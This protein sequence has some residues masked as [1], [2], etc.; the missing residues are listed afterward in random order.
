[1]AG[2]QSFVGPSDGADGFPKVNQDALFEDLPKEM[3]RLF[4]EVESYVNRISKEWGKTVKETTD[5]VKGVEG[6]K[7]GAGRL[8]LA[9]MSRNE[10]IGMGLGLAAMGAQT[11][12]SMAPNTMAAVTQRLSADSYAGM[13]GMSSRQAILQANRQVGG[14]ATSAMGPT[15]AA[16]NLAYGGYTANSLSSKNIMGQLAGLSAQSGMSNEAAAASVGGMNGMMFLRAGIRIRDNNGNLKPIDQ[17][18]NQVYNFLYRGRQISSEEAQLV[19]N[20]GS[21]SYSTI[22]QLA[23]GDQNLMQQ[24]QAGIVARTRA[25]SGKAY[26]AAMN[27][28]DPNKMLDIM[29]VDKSSPTR[30]QFRFNSS[31]NRKLAATEQGLV[32][33][34]NVA[35]RTTASVNDGFSTMAGLLGPINQGLM[36][37]KGI[38]QTMPGAG[39]TGAALSGLGGAASSL[40]GAAL[41]AK[42]LGN[43]LGGKGGGIGGFGGGGGG[44]A[45]LLGKFGPAT[46]VLGKGSML[47]KAGRVGL[48]AGVYAG[49]EWLQKFL[50]KK[51]KNL[52]SWARKLGN[53]AFDLG[54]GALTGLAAGGLGGAVAGTVAGGAGDLL[55]G[56]VGGPNDY[57]NLG[58][59]GVAAST[60]TG[61]TPKVYPTPAGTRIT[62]PFGP[63]RAD[64]HGRAGFHHGLDL[65]V[66]SG[67]DVRAFKDGHVSYIGN[68][69]KGYGNYIE[70]K[71]DDGTA[72]RYGHLRQVLV[73]RGQKVK[74]GQVIAKSGGNASDPGHGDSLHQHLHFEVLKNGQKVDPLPY[75]TGSSDKSR[76]YSKNNNSKSSGVHRFLSSPHNPSQKIVP[77]TPGSLSSAPLTSLLSQVSASGEP[78]SWQ[79]V[80]RKLPKKDAQK[81]IDSLPDS[82]KG[83]VTSDKKSLIRTISQQGFHGKALRT[84]YA[85]SIAESGGRS[86]AVGDVGLQDSKWGPSIGLFQIRSLK[87]WQQYNDPYRDASRL[88]NPNYN[89]QAAW[90]KSSN[91]RSFKAWSTYTSGSFLKHLSEADAMAKQTGVGGPAASVNLPSNFSTAGGMNNQSITI[92]GGRS[93]GSHVNVNLHMNVTIAHGSIQETDRIVRLIGEKLKNDHTLKQIASTL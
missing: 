72:T 4:K 79:D 37:L 73:T 22:A 46:G 16:M 77:I 1:M 64:D 30:S 18:I 25:K 87:H 48:A 33:G 89:A 29:G 11:Y 19:Y 65:G 12:M 44:M 69:A 38:L 90:A 3:L 5:A 31:E 36:T 13:S 26:S 50:N 58:T 60:S 27:S 63:R 54:E 76:G 59:A 92:S 83:P 93:G 49:S 71:H 45:G 52:P 41:Q 23:G 84:A 75:L 86:N 10:K 9:S 91:G 42:I 20:T 57:G 47:G 43:M 85:I 34:Y 8:G 15:M 28:K 67:T 74:A 35:L 70:I 17:I 53:F 81:Y 39:N 51:G 78:L 55:G 24:I 56:G 61:D 82:Y 21:R 32:G 68:E 2:G 66:K 7:V 80:I 62:S 14:G 6:N 40:G 88:P